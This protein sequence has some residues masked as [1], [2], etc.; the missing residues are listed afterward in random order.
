VIVD[1]RGDG[2]GVGE[3]V[4]ATVP[5]LEPVADDEAELHGGVVREDVGAGDVDELVLD[6][7]DVV[8]PG[9]PVEF[10]AAAYR[11]SDGTGIRRGRLNLRK[12]QHETLLEND[13]VSLAAV[14]ELDED[15]LEAADQ[16]DDLPLEVLGLLAVPADRVET[17][18]RSD[19]YPLEGPRYDYTQLRWSKLPFN[20]SLAAETDHEHGN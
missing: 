1:A 17:E 14:Y 6:G 8:E 20:G 16:D 11:I 2:D 3:D 7:I 9:P 18:Y 19:W 15:D 5:G 12:Q 4:V 13:G 10:K